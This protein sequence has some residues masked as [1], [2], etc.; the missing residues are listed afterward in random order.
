LPSS[1]PHLFPPHYP[2]ARW[3][4]SSWGGVAVQESALELRRRDLVRGDWLWTCC[5]VT[6]RGAQACP[7]A[8]ER[9]A[10]LPSQMQRP[11]ALCASCP[12]PPLRGAALCWDCIDGFALGKRSWVVPG[13][14]Q[15][16]LGEKGQGRGPP[17]ALAMPWGG[18]TCGNTAP[19][20][21]DLMRTTCGREERQC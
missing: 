21:L 10:L 18:S 20:A 3:R 4:G 14:R 6:R 9:A 19:S 16:P 11:R 5:P 17:S 13:R 1:C 7:K 8:A 2:P 12:A 15:S